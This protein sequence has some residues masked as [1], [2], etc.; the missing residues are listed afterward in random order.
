MLTYIIGGVKDGHF[1]HLFER[2]FLWLPLIAGFGFC[3]SVTI[4]EWKDSRVWR[5]FGCMAVYKQCPRVFAWLHV[6]RLGCD[7]FPD[8]VFAEKTMCIS[9][10]INRLIFLG[11]RFCFA[12]YCLSIWFNSLLF[13]LDAAP[14]LD[15]CY[16]VYLN[17]AKYYVLVL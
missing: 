16:C 9:E 8:K 7:L 13:C 5:G 14:R 1:F 17:C 11:F 4:V 10:S 3:L 6:L 2:C 12:F 15:P